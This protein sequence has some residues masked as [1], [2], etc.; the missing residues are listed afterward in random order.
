MTMLAPPMLANAAGTTQAGILLGST[1]ATTCAIRNSSAGPRFVSMF[2]ITVITPRSMNP[3]WSARV[4]DP[5]LDA[6][7]DPLLVGRAV[8]VAAG[9]VLR[10]R[11]NAMAQ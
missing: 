9:Q 7:Q 3:G 6:A 8:E 4:G 10:I 11:E 1:C 2:R 5:G